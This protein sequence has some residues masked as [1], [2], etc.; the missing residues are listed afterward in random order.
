MLETFATGL[1]LAAVSGI[2]FLAYKHPPAFRKL[3]PIIS[4][5][6]VSAQILYLAY[7][8]GAYAVSVQVHRAMKDLSMMQ[9]VE[10][11]TNSVVP[12]WWLVSLVCLAILL[13]VSFLLSLPLLIHEKKEP[14]PNHES[15][16]EKD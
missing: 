7:M 11:A 14:E 12:R 13:Y 16:E 6:T 9:V 1:L 8:A 3:A 10:D 4:V 2:T 5:L 15:P